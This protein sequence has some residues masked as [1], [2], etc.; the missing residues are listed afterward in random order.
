MTVIEDII[1][2]LTEEAIRKNFVI[3]C[4]IIEEMVDFGYP[5]L[6]DTEQVKD[7]VFN[8]PIV[9]LKDS[10]LKKFKEIFNPN[11]KSGDSSKKSI[12][13]IETSTNNNEIFFDLIEKISC[14][15]DRNGNII[16]SVIDG[17]IKMKRFLKNSPDLIIVFSDDIEFGKNISNGKTTLSGYNF[18][19]R[20]RSRDFESHKTLYILPLEGEF[21]LMNYR[22]NDELA[23]PFKIYNIITESNYKLELKIKLLSNFTSKNYASN[24]KLSFNSPKNTQSVYFDLPQQYKDRHKVDYN[25]NKHL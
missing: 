21:V 20:V 15:F 5:K 24:I 11:T 14:L 25:Q 16:Y 18:C 19:N 6:S 17:C 12:K 13:S 23:P 9:D 2:D 7:F 22:I 1:G 4:E 8:E 10:N 3:I